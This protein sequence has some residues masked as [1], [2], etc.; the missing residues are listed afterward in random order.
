MPDKAKTDA[1]GENADD[2]DVHPLWL[3]KADA[4]VEA[5]PFMQRYEGEVVLIKYGGQVMSDEGLAASCA[6]DIALLRQSGVYPVVVHGGAPQIGTMLRE[7]GIDTRFED[8]L[9]V[10]DSKTIKVVEMVLAGSINKHIVNAITQAG[11][12][13]V[14]LCG[15]DGGLMVARKLVHEGG[16]DLGFVGEPA[17]IDTEMVWSVLEAGL[18]PVIAPIAACDGGDTYNINADTAAGAIAVAMQA[19]RLLLLTDVS[20]VLGEDGALVPALNCTEARTMI[21]KQIITGGMIPKMQTSIRALE[22]GVEAVAI[23]DGRQ[24]HAVLLELLTNHGAGTLISAS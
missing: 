12:R 24:P 20:G 18:I 2:N 23:L 7:L 5:L 1:S 15:K 4:L 9:R 13:A 22:E 21:E 19:R 6:R 14:G 11:A 17:R 8:G 16:V 10:T 3:E